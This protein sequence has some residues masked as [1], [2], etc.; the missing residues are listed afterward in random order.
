MI[1]SAVAPSPARI[2]VAKH[3]IELGRMERV[4]KAVQRHLKSPVLGPATLC[5]LVGVSRSNLYRLLEPT[6]GVA[7]YIQKHRLLEAHSILSNS[8]SNITISAIADDLCFPDA[9]SFSRAFKKEFGCSPSD[10]R[11]A[12]LAGFAIPM[13]PLAHRVGDVAD[14]SD[15][16][17]DF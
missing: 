12:A 9:S 17:R 11:C 7:H 3:Q 10:A 15:L 5:R 1:A 13:M 6:G 4:R 16:L 14:F 8:E 2:A